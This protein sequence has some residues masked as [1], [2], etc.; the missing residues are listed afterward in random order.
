MTDV[1]IV[2]DD[3]SKIEAACHGSV[4]SLNWDGRR[5]EGRSL[6]ALVGEVPGPG[7]GPTTEVLGQVLDA[8]IAEI[9]RPATVDR[10][11]RSHVGAHY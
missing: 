11:L 2:L 5:W 1:S 7:L 6:V 10:C 4:W 9:D 3:G 8:L